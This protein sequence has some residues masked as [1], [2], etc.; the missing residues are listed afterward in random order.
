[1]E[2]PARPPRLRRGTHLH[3]ETNGSYT[4]VGGEEVEDLSVLP[5]IMDPKE[6]PADRAG[7]E[8]GDADE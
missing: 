4:L 2:E 3:R 7:T 6:S 8:P 1:M 5:P